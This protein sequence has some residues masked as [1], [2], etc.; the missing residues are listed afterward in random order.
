MWESITPRL[1]QEAGLLPRP[2]PPAETSD[3]AIKDAA[4]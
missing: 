2:E 4:A 1:V 3:A